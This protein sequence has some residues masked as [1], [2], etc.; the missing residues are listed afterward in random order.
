MCGVVLYVLF[1]LNFTYVKSN[2]KTRII[3]IERQYV[4]RICKKRLF[5]IVRVMTFVNISKILK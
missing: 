1:D 5:I 3:E 4:S 2:I